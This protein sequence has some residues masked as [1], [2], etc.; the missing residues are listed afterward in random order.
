[1]NI[2]R[3]SSSHTFRRTSTEAYAFVMPIGT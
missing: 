3:L 1:M 2:E